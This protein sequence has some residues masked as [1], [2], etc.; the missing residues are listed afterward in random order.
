[1]IRA[2]LTIYGHGEL[3]GKELRSFKDWIQAVATELKLHKPGDLSKV[4]RATLY[5]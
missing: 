5:K 3:K 2:R 1:M 4:F